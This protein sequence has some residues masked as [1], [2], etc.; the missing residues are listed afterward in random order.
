MRILFGTVLLE[1]RMG[2]RDWHVYLVRLGSGLVPVPVIYSAVRC[3]IKQ[4]VYV[5]LIDIP[6]HKLCVLL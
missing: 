5:P 6:D 2:G 1:W 3:H 4:L